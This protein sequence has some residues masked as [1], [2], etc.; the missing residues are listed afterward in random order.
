[1]PNVRRFNNNA[2]V[3]AQFRTETSIANPRI[4]K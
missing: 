1:M 4:T 3:M 2:Q